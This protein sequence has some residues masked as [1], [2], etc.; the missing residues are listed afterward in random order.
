MKNFLIL[1]FI[2]FLFGSGSVH[3][4][5]GIGLLGVGGGTSPLEKFNPN[6][7]YESTKD[8]LRGIA[9]QIPESIPTPQTIL[10]FGKN[11]LAGVPVQLGF[12]IINQACEYIVREEF[13]R[14][15]EGRH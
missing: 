3:G 5:L 15:V 7:L 2:R 6:D 1:L 12:E 4:A 11:M 14:V 9:E 8:S 10:S 13:Y